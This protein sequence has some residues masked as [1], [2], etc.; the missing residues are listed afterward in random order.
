M[1][2]RKP[3]NRRHRPGAGGGRPR[4]GRGN[5]RPNAR[6]RRRRKRLN[7]VTVLLG[8]V[9]VAL[10]AF[11][12]YLMLSGEERGGEPLAAC[13]VVLDRSASAS[14]TGLDMFEPATI[15]AFEACAQRDATFALYTLDEGGT[16]FRQAGQYELYPEAFN[17]ETRRDDS[18]EERV[19]AAR[20]SLT[21]A[22]DTAGTKDSGAGSNV[23][24][25]MTQAGAF[26]NQV[27]Q[28]NSVESRHLVVLSDGLHA[29]SSLS[30]ERLV[31]DDDDAITQL[32]DTAQ[33]S[34][35]MP[36]L[37]GIN[38]VVAGVGGGETASGDPLPDTFIAD[39][40][41]FWTQVVQASGGSLCGEP[42]PDVPPQ[43]VQECA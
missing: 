23:L 29:S 9:G 1:A 7:L 33:S 36:D 22:L 15:D 26:L 42:L 3:R 30:V 40:Q 6:P 27:A 24:G 4:A 14:G 2:T 43:V 41:D 31:D 19:G 5:R 39:L 11:L 16:G 35:V 38:V 32:V 18:R 20:E 13:A 12:A 37:D 25:A 17:T 28:Q 8:G 34:G 21:A 10:V